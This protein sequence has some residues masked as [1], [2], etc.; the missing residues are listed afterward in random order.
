[1]GIMP[2]E[3]SPLE[4]LQKLYPHLTEEEL[5]QADENLGRYVGL[6]LRIFERTHPDLEDLEDDQV[7]GN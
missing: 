1:V 3:E 5:A 7:D 2:P 4:L 6:V